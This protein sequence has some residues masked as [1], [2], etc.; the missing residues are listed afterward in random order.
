MGYSAQTS[1]QW[2]CGQCW[3]GHRRVVHHGARLATLRAGQCDRGLATTWAALG[4][5]GPLH[6]YHEGSAAPQGSSAEHKSGQC[7]SR[8]HS[9]VRIHCASNRVAQ[10]QY[11]HPRDWHARLRPLQANGVRYQSSEVASHPQLGFGIAAMLARRGWPAANGPFIR[12]LGAMRPRRNARDTRCSL[13]Q[14]C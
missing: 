10:L 8:R 1:L 4:R 13:G 9:A 11:M 6:A 5:P 14:V 3:G 7:L 2:Y 12:S